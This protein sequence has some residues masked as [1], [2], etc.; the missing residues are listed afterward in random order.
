MISMIDY[1]YLKLK[2]CDKMS[3]YYRML[4]CTYINV[5]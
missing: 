1:I 3:Q 4:T 5:S 2:V